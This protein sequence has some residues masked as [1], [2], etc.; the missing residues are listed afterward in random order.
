MAR[1]PML[2]RGNLMANLA[3]EDGFP[4]LDEHFE[5]TVPGLFITSMPAGRD[6]GPFFGFTVSARTSAK[7]IGMALR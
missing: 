7:L 4:V 6:F 2:A 3:L 5:S 1:I